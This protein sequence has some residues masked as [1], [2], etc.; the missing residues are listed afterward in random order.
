MPKSLPSRKSFFEIRSN[1]FQ[2]FVVPTLETFQK[3]SLLFSLQFRVVSDSAEIN[4]SR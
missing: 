4:V 2:A 1:L 3:F